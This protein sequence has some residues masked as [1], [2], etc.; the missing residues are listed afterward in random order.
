[1]HRSRVKDARKFGVNALNKEAT[2]GPV[3]GGMPGPGVAGRPD[4]R[5][6]QPGATRRLERG[7]VTG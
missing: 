5:G 1:V 7:L 3:D 6:N 2:P 4:G